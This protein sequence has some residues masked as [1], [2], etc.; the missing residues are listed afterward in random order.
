[1]Q[2]PDA[3][4]PAAAIAIHDVSPATWHECRELL[5][6]LDAAGAR[7]VS[8]LVIPNY[9]YRAPVLRDRAFRSAMDERLGRGDELVL[10][11]MYHVDT[12]PSPRTPRS[13]VE[14]RLMTR[15]EGEFAALPATAA[16]WRIAHGISMFRKLGWPLHGFV[17]SA[18]LISEAARAA[19]AEC[20]HPFGYMTVRRGVYRLPG[21]RF[22]RTANLCYSPFSAPRRA[23]SACA[24]RHE[25]RRARGTPLLRISLHPQDARVPGVMRHWE[26]LIGDALVHR[27][28]VT[29]RE[30]V[31]RF[32]EP[33]QRLPLRPGGARFANA[34]EDAAQ[35]H[36]AS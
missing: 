19:L 16:A 21:W 18:W 29:K 31:A 24:I 8:L 7:P 3:A 25:L 14:R 26:R 20:G 35:A 4:E 13:F 6:M 12:E 33:E 9:H 22:E 23:F 17:P 34:V 11:G 5:A 15:S 36:S 30:W 27:R 32:R 28:P 10:H 2:H 1:M